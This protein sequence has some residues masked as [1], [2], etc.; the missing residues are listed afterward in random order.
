MRVSYPVFVVRGNQ[1][2]ETLFLGRSTARSL[3]RNTCLVR[4]FAASPLSY[5]VLSYNPARSLA[6]VVMKASNGGRHGV[7]QD[8]MVRDRLVESSLS[9]FFSKALMI[10]TYG[11]SMVS[12]QDMSATHRTSVSFDLRFICRRCEAMHYGRLTA[13]LGDG[14]SCPRSP[15]STRK[16]MEAFV[17]CRLRSLYGSLDFVHQR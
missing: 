10:G 17:S 11:D 1:L 4:S 7:R 8:L 16:R 15:G 14:A 5:L 9:V 12:I 6:Y 2:R 3:D 13:D